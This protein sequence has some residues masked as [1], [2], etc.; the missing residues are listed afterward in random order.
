LLVSQLSFRFL[1]TPIV[2]ITVQSQYW[3]LDSFGSSG[4]LAILNSGSD[5]LDTSSGYLNG[6]NG[7]P[8]RLLKT[9]T[10]LTDGQIGTYSGNDGKLYQTICIGTQEW[11]SSDLMETKYRNGDPIVEVT[12]N[13]AWSLLTTG[14]RCS[15]DN[16][17]AN[18]GSTTKI[19]SSDDWVVPTQANYETLFNL[20]GTRSSN[21]WTPAGDKL[22]EISLV[23]WGTILNSTN[24][25]GFN[26]R[27]AGERTTSGI[28]IGLTAVHHLRTQT[29]N[30]STTTIVFNIDPDSD[31]GYFASQHTRGYSLRLLYVGAGTPTEYTGN[32]GKLYRVVLIGTQYWLADNLSETRFRDGSIIPWYGADSAN[33]FTNAE[34]AALTAAGCCAYNNTLSN[35][36]TGFTFPV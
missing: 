35:V 27:G 26:S 12:D 34:W 32:D 17:E 5:G 9:S 4:S 24:E 22:R 7:R 33:Y 31:A 30:N 3:L 1:P 25:V 18:A 8:L 14:A 20:L 19:S 10:T 21:S 23:Y 36:A 13:T 29:V 11:L 15:Y 6:K 16:I 28:F 2:S